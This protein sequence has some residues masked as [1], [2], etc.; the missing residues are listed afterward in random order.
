MRFA[1]I[2]S[3]EA[4]E[5]LTGSVLRAE[6][7]STAQ[8][9]LFVHELIGAEVVERSGP[10]RGTVVAVEANPASDLL[11]L[12]SGAL[13]PAALR[14][15]LR[16]G[17]AYRGGAGGLVR[18]LIMRAEIF[19]I[20]PDLVSTWCGASLLGK[21]WRGGAVDIVVHDLRSGAT[22]PHR[23][24]DDSPFGGGAGMVLAPGPGLS[25]PW[26]RRPRCGRSTCSARA[27]G[28]S[29][30]PWPGSWPR[31]RAASRCCAAATREWTSGWPSTWST[32]SCASGDY[33]L[34][35]GEAAALVVVEAVAR[36][37][38]GVHGQP[39]FRRGGELHRRVARVPA[40][41]PAG[42]VPGLGRPRGPPVGAPRARRPLEEGG[43]AG[44]DAGAP[45]RPGGG[46]GSGVRSCQDVRHWLRRVGASI[47]ASLYEEFM[48]PTDLIDRE[49]LRDDVPEFSPGRHRK[50][51]RA[52]GRGQ[53]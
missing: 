39:G 12:D 38:P 49:S 4:A 32:A 13:V 52:G 2:D 23:S 50:G 7:A 10:S 43:G 45:A 1:G 28:V 20:F 46:A 27:G 18:A 8:G 11:V 21:A 48:G 31:S 6:P 33:V 3:R 16:A 15:L 17:P 19:T 36:L 24:V 29:T 25:P 42:R 30:R 53:P 22:D 5:G 44:P 37:V 14:R 40:L 26:R 47:R 51:P 35:G 9:A 34:A 41:H